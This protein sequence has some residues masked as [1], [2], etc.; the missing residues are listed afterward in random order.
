[1][2]KILFYSSVSDVSLFQTQKFYKIDVDILTDLGYQV[3]T[4]N[5]ISDFLKCSRYDIAYIYFYRYG[6]FGAILAKLFGKKVYFTGGID[7]L[8]KTYA[9]KKR[10]FMQSVFFKLCLFFSTQCILVSHTD[11]DNVK[12]IYG[13]RLPRKTV[14]SFHAFDVQAYQYDD[15]VRKNNDF[16]SIAWMGTIPNVLRKGLDKAVDLFELLKKK[17][18][19]YKD[20]RF[21]IV[22]TQGVGSEFLKEKVASQN[23]ND[24]VIFTGEVDE[25]EKI[26]LL[27]NSRYYFQLSL[28]EGF[29]VAA[30]EALAA[31][32]VVLTSGKGGLKDSVGPHGVDVDVDADLQEQIDRIH[33]EI[34][35]V[36][37]QALRKAYEYVNERF[38]YPIRKKDFSRIIS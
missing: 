4:S 28:Y 38:S 35:Q 23:L 21:L 1:M 33:D 3:T 19:A 31:G 32:N 12:K 7:A 15:S 5:K 8:D 22:G 11:Q 16:I 20:S 13:G 17:Y 24:S 30:A 6:L 25:H 2:K 29:G 27:K 14:L 18:P 9:S 36:D 34:C 10:Y 37:E 26:E